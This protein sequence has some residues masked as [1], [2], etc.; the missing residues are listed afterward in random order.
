MLEKTHGQHSHSLNLGPFTYNE[1]K[2]KQ[3]HYIEAV[4]QATI[5]RGNASYSTLAKMLSKEGLATLT[6]KDY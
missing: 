4:A 2:T 3:P 6:T 5:H 1:H